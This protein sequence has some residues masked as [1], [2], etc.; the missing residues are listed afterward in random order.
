[1][2]PVLYDKNETSFTTFG[3]G[4]LIDCISCKVTEERNGM[5]ELE[6]K[7]P[8]GGMYYKDI[9]WQS[10]IKALPYED[11]SNQ[12]FRVYKISKPINGIVTIN[13]EHISYQLSYIPVKPYSAATASQ[14]IAGITTNSLISN[15]FSFWTDVDTNASL[16]LK[17]PH[18]ARAILG[19]VEGSILDQFGGEYE[20]DNKTVKLWKSRGEDNGVTLRYG[21]NITDLT[22]DEDLSSTVT[23]ILPYW[24]NDTTVVMGDISKVVVSDLPYE[25]IETTDVTSEMSN[26]DAD[27]VPTKAE[28]TAAGA[29]VL[30]GKSYVGVPSTNI[31]V[32]FAALWQSEEYKDIE[33]LEKVHLCD[34]VTVIFEKLGI[35]Q[36]AKVVKTEFD[37]LKEQ[38][39]SVEIGDLKNGVS[40]TLLTQ[41]QQIA[42]AQQSIV[43]QGQENKKIYSR[44]DQTDSSITAEVVNRQT[45][46]N[47]L[48][49]RIALTDSSITAEV[50]NR[51]AG[52]NALS[53]KIDMSINS[54][55]L[56]VTNGST[57][58]LL[59]LTAGDT[60]LA[61]QNIVMNGLV[62]FTDL[63]GNGTTTINGANI[64]TGTI[65]AINID[66]CTITG[67][68][69]NATNTLNV[70]YTKNGS[71][72]TR[73]VGATLTD[74]YSLGGRAYDKADQAVIEAESATRD[75]S[76]LQ[77]TVG[78]HSILISDL[79]ALKMNTDDPYISSCQQTI[80]STTATLTI[81]DVSGGKGY[82]R[83]IATSS[84]KWKYDIKD[85][86]DKELDP[87]KLY[88]LSV[89]QFVFNGDYLDVKD[90]RYGVPVIGLIAEE[91]AD[92]YPVAADYT[93]DGS[94]EIVNWNERYMIPAMLKLI[95]EQH[96]EIETLKQKVKEIENAI[97]F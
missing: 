63:S 3:V 21:K 81:T 37:V 65:S 79:N 23:G 95:Q 70:K 50:A 55:T 28:V 34:S 91:V 94:G 85:V 51:I 87:K 61:S 41:Q 48:S 73:E 86:L 10:Y 43:E 90:S 52:D 49:S 22:Q 25:R 78:N 92:V 29:K 82:I 46:D 18:S 72:Y 6:M 68:T 20:W 27:Y 19:G 35:S 97:R 75:I 33:A 17:E 67:T 64:K 26:E 88:S 2:I 30:S 74:L 62:S 77:T 69:I 57:S 58:S 96:E 42:A 38:Y 54:I 80:S 53:S 84:K 1:M 32:S 44:I 71:S 47:E 14:A 40:G 93:Q 24:K 56:K 66:G 60:V 7:Y 31:K 39:V 83:H 13:A 5:Y 59:V 8:M 12:L 4:V 36:K 45:A 16:A 76:S 11:A 15:P 89:R 9:E